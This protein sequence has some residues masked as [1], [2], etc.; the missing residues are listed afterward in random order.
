VY[1]YAEVPES[2]L[3]KATQEAHELFREAGVETR[4]LECPFRMGQTEARYLACKQPVSATDA[5]LRIVPPS[6]EPCPNVRNSLG[7]TILLTGE[8]LP[9]DG[10]VL[11]GKVRDRVRRCPWVSLPRLVGYVM[12][13]EL[14]H[15]LIGHEIHSRRGLMM[16][17]WPE[18]VL[19]E[20]NRGAR[21]FSTDEVRLLREGATARLQVS[22]Q[23]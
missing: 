14:A 6:M 3:Q 16:R 4:W 19:V 22:G 5:V 7:Y 21:A 11:Y 17:S 18:K 15:L 13:H 10:Y 23:Q 20:M 9:T 12:A 8:R 2:V 1:N